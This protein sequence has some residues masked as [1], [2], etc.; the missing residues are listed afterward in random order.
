MKYSKSVI[1]ITFFCFCWFSILTIPAQNLVPNG[2]FEEYDERCES[3][4]VSLHLNCVDDWFNPS[5]TSPDYLRIKKHTN[6]GGPKKAK[7]GKA[8]VRIIFLGD[9]IEFLAV[10][11]KSPLIKGATYLVKLSTLLPSNSVYTI[12]K[13]QLKF[14]HLAFDPLS[15]E[16]RYQLSPDLTTSNFLSNTG[17]WEEFSVEY[18]AKGNEEFLTI[19][20]FDLIGKN[21]KRLLNIKGSLY[22][23]L[24]ID[25]VSIVKLEKSESDTSNRNSTVMDSL[26]INTVH[27]QQEQNSFFD[28]ITIVIL[29]NVYFETNQAVL[30]QESDSTLNSLFNYLS[31]NKNLKASIVGHTDSV[32]NEEFNL[33]LSKKRA[34]AVKDYLLLKGIDSSRLSSEGKGSSSPIHPNTSKENRAL[35][36]RVEIFFN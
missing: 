8:F 31:R 9:S 15:S 10:R 30:L 12:N 5:T 1:K 36:R 32:G 2:S 11:F 24:Y 6:K 33:S 34:E 26:I 16:N 22:Y 28:S 21:D 20:V 7:N 19:G 27:N 13:L 14:S 17:K 18:L 35:N 29:E 4:G 25:E 3:I 23:F